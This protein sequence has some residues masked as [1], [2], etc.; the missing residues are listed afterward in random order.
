MIIFI[1]Y[2]GCKDTHFSETT[3]ETA[4]NIAEKPII[5]NK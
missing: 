1:L 3:K 5:I 4:L 2:S